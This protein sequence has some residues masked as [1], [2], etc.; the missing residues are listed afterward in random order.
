MKERGVTLFIDFK[1][2]RTLGDLQAV[3]IKRGQLNSMLVVPDSLRDKMWGD[4]LARY[5][6]AGKQMFSF[7]G[8]DAR[9]FTD[10]K[11]T[12]ITRAFMLTIPTFP[13]KY[14]TALGALD[15]DGLV[16]QNAG[17]IE[18]VLFDLF[19]EEV[20]VSAIAGLAVPVFVCN[21][22]Y[23]DGI[24]V[25]VNPKARIKD[26]MAEIILDGPKPALAASSSSRKARRENNKHDIFSVRTGFKQ[27]I[28]E[29]VVLLKYN[30][31]RILGVMVPEDK[32]ILARE[33][34]E[35]KM[36][37]LNGVRLVLGDRESILASARAHRDQGARAGEQ[38]RIVVLSPFLSK[39]PKM[40]LDMFSSDPVDIIR[41]QLEKVVTYIP[42]TVFFKFK[43][44][45][46]LL[47]LLA[48][49][50]VYE[51]LRVEDIPDNLSSSHE[52]YRQLALTADEA[53]IVFGKMRN[54]N[55]WYFR[56]GRT[57]NDGLENQ[58]VTSSLKGERIVPLWIDLKM[59]SGSGEDI[60]LKGLAIFE[61]SGHIHPLQ[62]E[63]SREEPDASRFNVL[64]SISDLIHIAYVYS[65]SKTLV[66][67]RVVTVKE[68]CLVKYSGTE[69]MQSILQEYL[70]LNKEGIN[71]LGPK[72][73]GALVDL[74]MRVMD[75]DLDQYL[76][77]IEKLGFKLKFISLLGDGSSAIHSARYPFVKILE[78]MKANFE[79]SS[80]LQVDQRL[81]ECARLSFRVGVQED[82]LFA[83]D[84]DGWEIDFGC[85]YRDNKVYPFGSNTIKATRG[86]RGC[87]G[88]AGINFRPYPL[89]PLAF[90]LHPIY[91]DVTN[92][93]FFDFIYLGRTYARNAFIGYILAQKGN[94]DSELAKLRVRVFGKVTLVFVYK[95]SVQPHMKNIAHSYLHDKKF[96]NTRLIFIKRDPLVLLF[97]TKDGFGVVSYANDKIL[98]GCAVMGWD[99]LPRD[100]RIISYVM[101]QDA[102]QPY[103]E[104][105]Q[106]VL[107]GEHIVFSRVVSG[108]S[109]LSSSSLASN[110][111][112]IN[113][114]KEQ[115]H[116][117]LL[118]GTG[119]A[120]EDIFYYMTMEIENAIG[121]DE[122]SRKE[123]DSHFP[124][125]PDIKRGSNCIR[126]PVYIVPW[127]KADYSYWLTITRGHDSRWGYR[128]LYDMQFNSE[129]HQL[130]EEHGQYMFILYNLL[131]QV[132]ERLRGKGAIKL[133]TI[134][135]QTGAGK[136]ELAKQIERRGRT[137]HV[138]TDNYKHRQDVR[139]SK[140][141][142]GAD[143]LDR[144]TIVHQ[145]FTLLRGEDVW[146]RR[147]NKKTQEITYGP[148][149]IKKGDYDNLV[150]EGAY[151]WFFPEI[152]EAA[153][154][155]VLIIDIAGSRL[156]KKEARDIKLR[157]YP[158][159]ENLRV[160][161]LSELEESPLAI[162]P[163]VMESYADIVIDYSDYVA[164]GK[165]YIYVRK[166]SPVREVMRDVFILDDGALLFSPASSSLGVIIR[167]A[168][169][170][171]DSVWRIAYNPVLSRECVVLSIRNFDPRP[172]TH[173]PR[174]EKDTRHTTVFFSRYPL[175]TIMVSSSARAKNPW[176]DPA[177]AKEIMENMP[178]LGMHGLP[179]SDYE[180]VKKQDKW[181]GNVVIISDEVR[182][183]EPD[184][185]LSVI[186]E[187][188]RE[189]CGCG[190]K[191]IN[192]AAEVSM[193]EL[194]HLPVILFVKVGVE[195]IKWRFPDS[196]PWR[197][198][199]FW[200]DS[201]NKPLLKT[202]RI[203]R[204]D[205]EK[206]QEAWEKY[207]KKHGFYGGVVMGLDRA[208]EAWFRDKMAD[209]LYKRALKF[210]AE[211]ADKNMK[212][213]GDRG[214][215][216]I[217]QE[218]FLLNE[219]SNKW[220][221]MHTFKGRLKGFDEWFSREYPH[222]RGNFVD[223][224]IGMMLNEDGIPS[225]QTSL[226]FARNFPNLSVY[227]VDIF[228]PEVALRSG[229]YWA[230]YNADGECRI[231]EKG[232]QTLGGHFLGK[233]RK[234]QAVPRAVLRLYE[235]I[236]HLYSLENPQ[237][238]IISSEQEIIV[239]PF[240]LADKK[241]TV[242]FI[243]AGFRVL[244]GILE[245]TLFDY[246]R[247]F[248][249]NRHYLP[250]EAWQN[251]LYITAVFKEGGVLLEG[252]TVF[253]RSPIFAKYEITQNGLDFKGMHLTP[254]NLKYFRPFTNSLITTILPTIFRTKQISSSSATAVDEW[255]TIF[256]ALG[257]K[258]FILSS[259]YEHRYLLEFQPAEM[260]IYLWDNE[261]YCKRQIG[262]VKID[263]YDTKVVTI[264]FRIAEGHHS[265]DLYIKF[266]ELLK[267]ELPLGACIKCAVFGYENRKYVLELY[268]KD[269]SF[270][271]YGSN[272]CQIGRIF[273]AAGFSGHKL[274]AV[275]DPANPGLPKEIFIVTVKKESSSG[276]SSIQP[277]VK[278]TLTFPEAGNKEIGL[279]LEEMARSLKLNLTAAWLDIFVQRN[280]AFSV[281]VN[282]DQRP[283][284]MN[285]LGEL[286]GNAI[287]ASARRKAVINLRKEDSSNKGKTVVCIITNDG[288]LEYASLKSE[289]LYLVSM[290]ELWVDQ[291]AVGL[292]QRA[293]ELS[294][295]G[296]SYGDWDKVRGLIFKECLTDLWGLTRGIA[297]T[298]EDLELIPKEETP[299]IFGL[300]TKSIT[301]EN[302]GVGLSTACLEFKRMGGTLDIKAISSSSPLSDKNG[303]CFTKTPVVFGETIKS[304]PQSAISNL[305]LT[306]RY[307]Q[308]ASSGSSPL[309]SFDQVWQRLIGE[310]LL[311]ENS[312]DPRFYPIDNQYESD[313]RNGFKTMDLLYY[314]AILDRLVRSKTIE[315]VY[316][317]KNIDADDQLS[318]LRA[319]IYGMIR[320][321]SPMEH[322]CKTALQLTQILS[323]LGEEMRSKMGEKYELPYQYK[324]FM[325]ALAD[326]KWDEFAAL[327]VKEDAASS[328][329]LA[330]RTNNVFAKRYTL[331]AGSKVIV[332]RYGKKTL[333]GGIII[334]NSRQVSLWEE[335]RSNSAVVSG[336]RK[337]SEETMSDLRGRTG[338]NLNQ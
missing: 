160:F 12:R 71:L 312:P 145:M 193:D 122:I 15:Q 231:M 250:R 90:I 20:V 218:S 5:A 139:R 199:Q 259:A 95:G 233:V 40:G 74:L 156:F 264:S 36:R 204:R 294:R 16:V 210:F 143:E 127:K 329:L 185:F 10:D 2:V 21:K 243:E 78:Q 254:D 326:H 268:R 83:A 102:F 25:Y 304:N 144:Q 106:S 299:F 310:G 286:V 230:F 239:R 154:L 81:K 17:A 216:G 76:R 66:K 212:R 93:L 109:A 313:L 104:F 289:A 244:P 18:G 107:N 247:I 28:D 135:A 31:D 68:S 322:L 7:V 248:N 195:I 187:E 207:A 182:K 75:K 274:C 184:I 141:L 158:P 198:V 8:G 292:I 149:V 224:G 92:R 328:A 26:L 272:R 283:G 24:G 27:Q 278:V 64:P 242:T 131:F 152:R 30:Q 256:E 253:N 1:N 164:A 260:K 101:G 85:A 11:W 183:V 53:E 50:K 257:Q 146:L 290:K 181:H 228:I 126:I 161:A 331:D 41:Y 173:D 273:N 308:C 6:R 110:I 176:K 97:V 29:L 136:T 277:Y 249:A 282:L 236:L 221:S 335:L 56:K 119:A 280:A 133:M 262:D 200:P 55:I 44:F 192:N 52:F 333:A 82:L 89:D 317:I 60:F 175:N 270:L 94:I 61:E 19:A 334:D 186:K 84:R 118:P 170:L 232:R 300:S 22:F 215:S 51:Q 255:Q 327:V 305:V 309:E 168:S 116:V 263:A 120:Y 42:R 238:I 213:N 269:P 123:A 222:A 261:T 114:L 203:T 117:L 229:N 337:R 46:H 165:A 121:R 234:T 307:P 241:G 297:V 237:R 240:N 128:S 252:N 140:G 49:L 34:F 288:V 72:L 189:I 217:N 13:A 86:L 98:R 112:A 208:K 38:T 303:I 77:G 245:G 190:C 37:C 124:V 202:I 3:L 330:Y 298:T 172:T 275:S 267:E 96:S 167:D 319:L 67:H 188:M 226:D 91:E 47:G 153:D 271:Q 276:A 137:L 70:S 295:K 314:Q 220:H 281:N 4:S 279:D 33:E 320:P 148:E 9:K 108:I 227:G 58:I 35:R 155:R 325:W 209:I 132:L 39:V 196:L 174:L 100:N 321:E 258:E 129:V 111:S 201:E 166:N 147:I 206:I 291:R 57:M 45:S 138:E 88:I 197:D 159:E 211:L 163:Q 178:S 162:G 63:S 214:S 315:M 235:G 266:L 54:S 80:S 205:Y 87:V 301:D 318:L 73:P 32:F 287:G 43:E 48:D 251:L 150:L 302:W 336:R 338:D 246:G 142:K 105:T 316:W 79:V 171:A 306:K 311:D 65:L 59:F 265:D 293:R 285:S 69:I 130:F 177:R 284:F 103:P 219:D 323:F 23:V 332:L 194:K 169:Q 223:L 180:S 125:I 225:P 62:E 324:T 179:A 157:G 115:F 151:A 113:R 14:L 191:R 296:K 134:L 99:N